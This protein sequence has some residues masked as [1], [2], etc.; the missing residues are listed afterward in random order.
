MLC[1]L[2]LPLKLEMFPVFNIQLLPQHVL[3]PLQ[4]GVLAVCMF[5]VVV[6]FT[7]SRFLN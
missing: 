4:A 5:E 7:P 3:L 2:T 6:A 1:R